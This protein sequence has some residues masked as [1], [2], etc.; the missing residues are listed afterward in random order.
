MLFLFYRGAGLVVCNW[1]CDPDLTVG[2][3]TWRRFAPD[4]GLLLINQLNSAEV[5]STFERCVEPGPDNR[6]RDLLGQH[7][8]PERNHVGIVVLTP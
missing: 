1:L 2:A 8:L 5:A 7:P 6:Q 3:I 4:D